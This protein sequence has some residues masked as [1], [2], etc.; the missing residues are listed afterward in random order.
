MGSFDEAK[1]FMPVLEIQAGEETV[2]KVMFKGICIKEDIV[3]VD[4][5]KWTP[6]KE[7]GSYTCSSLNYLLNKN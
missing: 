1:K 5:I 6:V 2:I 3:V 7:I 4:N